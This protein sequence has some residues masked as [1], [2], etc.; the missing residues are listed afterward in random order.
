MVTI[1]NAEWMMSLERLHTDLGYT[2]TNVVLACV[3]FN[4][5]CQWSLHKIMSIPDLINTEISADFDLQLRAAL[6]AKEQ[7]ENTS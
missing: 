3:E 5:T 1:R 2:S 6:T 7:R 4:S